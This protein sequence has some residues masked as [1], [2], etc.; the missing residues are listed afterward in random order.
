MNEVEREVLEAD[1]LLV[2]AG[3][4]SLA[5]AYHLAHEMRRDGSEPKIVVLEKAAEVGEHVLSGAVMDTDLCATLCREEYGNPCEHF[6][7]AHVYE[8]VDDLDAESTNGTPVKKL[9]IHHSGC[10]HC[11]TCD[12]MDPYGVD[13]VVYQGRL[14]KRLRRCPSFAN[15]VITRLYST[16][17]PP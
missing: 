11:R 9:E 12:I 1:V 14:G 16:E 7:P 2:G 15:H 8:M 17:A 10:V 4:A 13:F 5:C 6:C 3:P